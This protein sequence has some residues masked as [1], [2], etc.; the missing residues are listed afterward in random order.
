MYMY[1]YTYIHTYIRTHTIHTYIHTYM[2]TYIHT[3]VYAYM[4]T[5][6][7][8]CIHK[9]RWRDSAHAG[10][11]HLAVC[12]EGDARRGRG[13][14]RAG[15]RSNEN[16]GRQAPCQRSSKAVANVLLMCC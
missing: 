12:I 16:A 4:H 14:I 6:I 15:T 2:H 10:E 9:Y 5:Y 1:V 13:R 7:R 11:C 3:Y 8:I